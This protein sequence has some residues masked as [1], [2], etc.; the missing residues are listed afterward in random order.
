MRGSGEERAERREEAARA[1]E[2][3]DALVAGKV[4][5]DPLAHARPVRRDVQE[6]HLCPGGEGRPAG[7]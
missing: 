3:D 7:G 4:L 5:E 2:G 1:L 6:L